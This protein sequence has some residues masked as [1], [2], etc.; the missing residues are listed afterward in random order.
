MFVWLRV[1]GCR[2]WMSHALEAFESSE[3][4][5][6]HFLNSKKAP[7]VHDATSSIK[8]AER[9]ERQAESSGRC[10]PTNGDIALM[11]GILA[12]SNVR[13]LEGIEG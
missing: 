10:F 2:N 5:L 9:C 11:E 6:T 7:T 12:Q 13:S 3:I 8:N 4:I 1:R